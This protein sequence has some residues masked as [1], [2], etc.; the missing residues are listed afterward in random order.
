MRSSAPGLSAR[1]ASGERHIGRFA[2]EAGAIALVFLALSS[3]FAFRFVNLGTV[4]DLW[5]GADIPR[6]ITWI[7]RPFY[8]DRWHLHPLAIV[9]LKAYGLLLA[10]LRIPS[11]PRLLPIHALPTIIIVAVCIVASARVITATTDTKVPPFT[12]AAGLAGFGSMLAFAPVPECHAA[13]GALLLLQ[14]ALVH[15]WLNARS[16]GHPT[17]GRLRIGILVAGLA[18]TGFTL[19][20]LLPALIVASPVVISNRASARIIVPALIAVIGLGALALG[21]RVPM[22]NVIKGWI[23]YE[24]EWTYLPTPTT[25]RESFTGLV[26]YQFGVP[27]A[28]LS[29]WKNPLDG[30]TVMSITAR[31]PSA[32]HFMA[33]LAWAAGIVLWWGTR[34]RTV[35]DKQLV[36]LTS[37]A[38]AS[39][40]AFHSVYG[41]YESYVT[42]P[43]VWP[44]VAIPGCLAYVSSRRHGLRLPAGLIVATL[45]LSLVQSATGLRSLNG[46]PSQPGH[47]TNAGTTVR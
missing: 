22:P 38:G 1:V 39:L 19:S 4:W 47:V 34:T 42:S 37:L 29:T 14:A 15:A 11:S 44:Y 45:I 23:N 18:A 27:A 2:L 6:V 40:V 41:S 31:G 13:G 21:L 30:T 35:A 32:L 36:I 28:Q 3:W 12:I 33:L 43:H 46:L 9:P 5:F 17:R 26:T 8:L 24:M 10:V 16:A 20:N 25:L 7:D